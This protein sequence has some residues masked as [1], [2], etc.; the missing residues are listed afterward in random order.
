MKEFSLVGQQ[1]GKER[2]STNHPTIS[3]SNLRS[4]SSTHV[5]AV[6]AIS[7]VSSMST[8]QVQ[9]VTPWELC[10]VTPSPH[11][12]AS[13]RSEDKDR[14]PVSNLDF[15]YPYL[16][17]PHI[18]SCRRTTPVTWLSLAKETFEDCSDCLSF[19]I[20]KTK[21]SKVLERHTQQMRIGTLCNEIAPSIPHSSLSL[22]RIQAATNSS[23]LFL[24]G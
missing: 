21:G 4:P 9:E 1:I 20:T 17:V 18:S 24:L 12:S 16:C 10:P 7:M 6:K 19:V 15:I 13:T 2:V 8:S 3:T 5:P 22:F 14:R 11:R 23:P